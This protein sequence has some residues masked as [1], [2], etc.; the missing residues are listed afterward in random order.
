M[1]GCN[2]SNFFLSM[3]GTEKGIAVQPSGSLKR[4]KVITTVIEEE[5][6]SSSAACSDLSSSPHALKFPSSGEQ[7]TLFP[8]SENLQPTKQSSTVQPSCGQPSETY[9]QI[10]SP[11]I[12]QS[13]VTHQAPSGDE[14]PA[15]STGSTSH[16]PKSKVEAH[17]IN[18][19]TTSRRTG[20][21]CPVPESEVTHK[22]SPGVGHPISSHKFDFSPSAAS[23]T[24]SQEPFPLQPRSDTGHQRKLFPQK[25]K[26]TKRK[27]PAAPSGIPTSAGK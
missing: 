11:A 10:H 7:C 20:T 3:Q 24:T 2:I 4:R 6:I 26:A 1:F 15:E 9:A 21:T 23:G 18:L 25:E 27:V 17:Y 19:F 22:V 5:I 12:N 16:T 13:P 8:P 14:H